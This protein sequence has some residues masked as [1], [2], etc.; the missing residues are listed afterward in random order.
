MAR[1]VHIQIYAAI[2]SVV[3]QNSAGLKVFT[4]CT[5][6]RMVAVNL[7]ARLNLMKT[8]LI[9]TSFIPFTRH[10]HLITKFSLPSGHFSILNDPNPESR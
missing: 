3:H 2:E 10:F 9:K 6:D 7:H 4:L 8:K 5:Y 1:F